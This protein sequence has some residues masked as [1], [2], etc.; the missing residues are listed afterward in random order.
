RVA[1]YAAGTGVD[2]YRARRDRSGHAAG[3]RGHRA[4]GGTP[5][6]GDASDGCAAGVARLGAEA[7]RAAGRDDRA[8]G[9]EDDTGY[10]R[11]A[12]A[13]VVATAAAGGQPSQGERRDPPPAG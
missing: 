3:H 4:V 7:R 2:R 1:A 10:G 11:R 8:A 13:A 9:T 6:E 12:P 5:I